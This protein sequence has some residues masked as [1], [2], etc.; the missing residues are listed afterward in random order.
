MSTTTLTF[1]PISR[2]TNSFFE[3]D[4]A[5]VLYEDALK[6][7]SIEHYP[8]KKV[9]INKNLNQAI[10]IVKS[11][12]LCVTHKDAFDLGVTVFENVFGA[13]PQIHKEL[14][15]QQTTDYSVDLISENCKIVFDS[16][17]YRFLNPESSQNTS[18]FKEMR[19]N[20]AVNLNS[21]PVINPEIIAKN[22]YDEYFPFI[23]VSNYLREGNSFYIELGYYRYRCSNGMMLGRKTKMTFRHTYYVKDFN[24]IKDAAINQFLEYKRDFLN[25]AEKLWRILSVYVPKDQMK[26][27]VYDIL[28][29]EIIKKRVVE[30]KRLQQSLKDLTDIYVKD[31][32]ENMNAVLNVATDA[33]KL[34]ESSRVSQSVVQNLATTWINRVTKQTFHIETYLKEIEHIEQ[35]ILMAKEAIEEEEGMLSMM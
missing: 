16:S 33:S 8:D 25:M 14:F 2:L 31:I 20:E 7:G 34:L 30:R 19:S 5:S 6:R 1:T 22:F 10:S 4:E 15:N 21:D 23:R 11:G 17:G 24:R 12:F 29:K 35:R 18:N 26:L 27:V 3:I 9:I 13:T 28:E 32:G